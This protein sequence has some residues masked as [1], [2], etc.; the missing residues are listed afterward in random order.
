[1]GVF[2]FD[3]F[4]YQERPSFTLCNPNQDELYSINMIYD[5]KL[6]LR[7]NAQSEF[8]FKIPKF[9][10]NQYIEAFDYV[11]S[12]R[13]VKIENLGYFIIVEV[14]DEFDGSVP[15]KSVTCYSYETELINKKIIL[16]SGTFRLFNPENPSD[17]DTIVGKILRD[18]PTWGVGVVDEDLYNIYRSFDISDNNYYNFITTDASR[19][20]DCI[21]YFDIMNKKISAISSQKQITETDIFLSFENLIKSKSSVQVSEEITTCMYCYGGGDLDIRGVNPLG[22]NAIYNFTY[23]KNTNW[24]SPNLISLIDAW[25]AKVNSY[26]PVYSVH[27]TNLNIKQ[28]EL[29]VL[30]AELEEYLANKTALEQVRAVRLQ[31]GLDT[32]DV[33]AQILSITNTINNQ[34][35]LI[36]VKEGEINNL[37]SIIVTINN[38]LSIDN[39]IN[40]PSAYR[41]ELS[42]FIF[43][44]TYK[45]ENI[46]VTDIMTP[47]EIE[48]QGKELYNDSVK[49]L[50]KLS[51]PRYEITINAVNFLALKE[52]Q[53]FID[54]LE[55]GGQLTIDSGEGYF[56][57]ATLLE[58][59]FSYENPD[60]FELI[61]SNKQ[62]IDNSSFVLTDFLGQSIKNDSNISFNSEKWGDWFDTK[63][64]VIGR[65]VTTG[66]KIDYGLIANNLAGRITASDKLIIRNIN[67]NTGEENFYLDNTGL[68]LRNPIIY[69]GSQVGRDLDLVLVGGGYLFFRNGIFI[70]GAGIQQGQSITT[71]LDI[72]GFTGNQYVLSGSSMLMGSL[73]V[74]INGITQVPNFT[75]EQVSPNVINFYDTLDAEDKILLEFVNL[76]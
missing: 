19:A 69:A 4:N 8:S 61:I 39:P 50:A 59:S 74:Y 21:F 70:G 53:S 32:T 68:T 28:N 66:S 44:N 36:A 31:Q 13:L 43:E 14:E 33:D 58:Y 24:M 3:Y 9:I 51:V 11:E 65:V 20:Y 54:Q 30:K 60:D 76:S 37:L 7:W 27:V 47:Q 29:L 48:Q 57:D 55:L 6:S 12:K 17:S 25:E 45:N 26:I 62:R 52:Y 2:Q 75:Y 10:D 1:M 16:L 34:N 67:T 42:N 46:I 72:S 73:R 56:I 38:D 49:M 35:N 71:L 23:Y 15:I 64:M 5:T 40:F 18:N 22:T 63:P 41:L